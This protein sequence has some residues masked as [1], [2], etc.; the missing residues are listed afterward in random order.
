MWVFG[1]PNFGMF[2]DDFFAVTWQNFATLTTDFVTDG[3][4]AQVFDVNNAVFA[5]DICGNLV[6]CDV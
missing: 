3:N 6:V 4:V 2:D 1:A 5:V